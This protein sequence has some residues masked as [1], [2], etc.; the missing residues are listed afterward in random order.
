[1]SILGDLVRTA[2][3]ILKTYGT[4]PAVAGAILKAASSA[5]LKVHGVSDV[6]VSGYDRVTLVVQGRCGDPAKVSGEFVT[7]HERTLDLRVAG[8]DADGQVQAAKELARALAEFERF[9]DGAYVWIVPDGYMAALSEHEKRWD[10]DGGGYFSHESMCVQNTGR[11]ATRCELFVYFEPAGREVLR[12]EFEI[13]AERSIHLRLDKLPARQG[14]PFVPKGV[15]VGY[16]IVSHQAPV[17]VQGSRI[18]TSGKDSEF[19]SFGTTMAWA[20]L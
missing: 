2:E 7:V 4:Q 10:R 20:P 12:H 13:P 14:E 11:R 17:V 8:L 5:A 15:P 19:A 16:K 9:G 1:M 6:V 3:D 18:L